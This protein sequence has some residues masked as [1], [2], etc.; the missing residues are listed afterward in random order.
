MAHVLHSRLK[1]LSVN[2]SKTA[3]HSTNFATLLELRTSP[4]LEDLIMRSNSIHRTWPHEHL[5][6]FLSRSRC[7]LIRLAFLLPPSDEQPIELLGRVPSLTHLEM[8]NDRGLSDPLLQRLTASGQGGSTCLA[9]HLQHLTYEGPYQF[10]FRLLAD[11]VLW[12]W[13]VRSSARG[14]RLSVSSSGVR[15]IQSLL[16]WGHRPY[17][18]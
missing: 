5:M 6:S 13:K 16:L 15:R 18:Q 2:I 8:H 9:P 4:A 12:R 11:T 1:I 7:M 3:V 14:N 10:D 17:R